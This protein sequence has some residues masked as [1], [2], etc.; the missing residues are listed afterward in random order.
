MTGGVVAFGETMM[1]LSSPR[2]GPLRV[3]RSLEMS[4]AG[5]ESNV[6]IGV[7]RLG[8]P[9]RWIG[10]VGDDE[11]GRLIVSTLRGEGVDV[12]A[13]VNH[14]APTGLMLK[15]RRTADSTSVSY[16][17]RN[18]AASCMSAEDLDPAWFAGV[19]VLHVTGI[20][21]AISATAR[22]TLEHSL[23]LAS[24]AGVTISFDV[25]FRS[26]L[27]RSEEAATVLAPLARGADILFAGDDELTLI[28]DAGA[29]ALAGLGPREVIITHGA[30][31]ATAY[32]DG[33]R[34][35]APLFKVRTIDPVGAGDAFVAGYLAARCR[36]LAMPDR[37]EVA[38]ATGAFAVTSA[39]DWEGAP[40]WEELQLLIAADG[41]VRR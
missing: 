40:S 4:V 8:V 34:W 35:E 28:G 16:Y 32:S 31:G 36:G 37:L 14:E 39:G 29:D 11:P 24:A 41:D 25:N 1:S 27:W 33:S 38:A 15:E 26:R 19:S 3:A 21:P 13:V 22:S 30:R 18:S 9:A 23:T 7:A 20:T 2:T 17:R 6:A 12:C 5:A 10:S